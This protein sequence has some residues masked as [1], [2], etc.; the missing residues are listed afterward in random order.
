MRRLLADIMR[1]LSLN[2]EVLEQISF[3]GRTDHAIFRSLLGNEH[4]GNSELYG[5]LKSSYIREIEHRMN[6]RHLHIYDAVRDC[7]ELIS[8]ARHPMGLLTG[9]YREIAARKLSLAKLDH[10][11]SFGAFGCNHTDRNMLGRE[12]L[13]DFEQHY[14]ASSK[15]K[16]YIII[17]D[18]PMDIRCAH[19]LG[20]TSIAVTTGHFSR[21]ELAAYKPDLILNNLANPERWLNEC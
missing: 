8:D 19:H 14:G 11:F 16:Q 20:C 3:A 9:N 2:T 15:P 10:Y 4:R 12:A 17:G 13:A 18:T 7:L 5:K 21:E 6:S 1:T